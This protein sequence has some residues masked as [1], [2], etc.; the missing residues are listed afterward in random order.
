MPLEVKVNARALGAVYAPVQS[1]DVELVLVGEKGARINLSGVRTEA[2]L[3]STIEGAS[4][5]TVV[6]H[7]YKRTILRSQVVKTAATIEF[8]GVLYRL[9]KVAHAENL[10]TLTLEELAVAILR[11]YDSPKK[12]NRD[13][14]TRAKFVES[15]VR[16]PK[17]YMIPF[18]CPERD[19][20]Q[21]IASSAPSTPTPS[22]P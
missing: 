17:D 14:V 1:L 3:E 12:A 16:E 22:S 18:M 11:T 19:V 15:L 8:D 20:R 9:V 6:V 4:T 10:L 21:P 13:S 7:D 5:L 2:T